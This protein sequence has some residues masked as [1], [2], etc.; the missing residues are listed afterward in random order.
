MI[1]K[2]KRMKISQIYR[3]DSAP[4]MRTKSI[5]PEGVMVQRL[6]LTLLACTRLTIGNGRGTASGPSD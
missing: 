1:I 3:T 5:D 6:G 4:R 2:E